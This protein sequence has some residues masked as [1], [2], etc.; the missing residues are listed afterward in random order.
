MSLTLTLLLIVPGVVVTLIT[1]VASLAAVFRVGNLKSTLET[2][3]RAATA[4]EEER[5][6]AVAKAERLETEIA[7]LVKRV[8]ELE[9]INTQ[10]QD[11]T[12]LSRY[13]AKQDE[14][15]EKTIAELHEVVATVKT[16]ATSMEFLASTI[17]PLAAGA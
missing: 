15:H 8:D 16:L 7:R 5:D 10:L 1:L 12:D 9:R 2:A 17:R 13:F 6:A 11:R 14:Q 4:W 3:E